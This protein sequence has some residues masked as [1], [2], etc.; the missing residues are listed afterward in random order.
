MNKQFVRDIAD[1]LNQARQR[2]KTAVNLS[3]VYAYYE[4][5]KRIVSEEQQGAQRAAYGQQVLAELSDYLTAQFGKGFSVANLK[6]IRRFYQVYSKDQIGET[7][8]SQLGASKNSGNN[9]H[10]TWRRFAPCLPLGEGAPVRTLGRMRGLH[11][12]LMQRRLF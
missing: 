9:N 5:G 4:I 10:C 1:I 8:F 2:A 7:V 6:N 11:P 12:L 3:M